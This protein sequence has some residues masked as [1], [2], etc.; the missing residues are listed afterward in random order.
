MAPRGPTLRPRPNVAARETTMKITSALIV[1]G[2]IGGMS[3]AIELRKRG[4]SVHLIDSDPDWRVYGAG[5]TITAPTL[6]AFRDLGVLDE[7]RAHGFLS[8]GFEVRTP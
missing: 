3:T 1:G 2:G 4:V 7:I 8:K 5:I 6:R